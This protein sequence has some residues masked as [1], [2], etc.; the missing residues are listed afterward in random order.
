MFLM[1]N[2]CKVNFFENLLL[3]VVYYFSQLGYLAN[4]LFFLET[5]KLQFMIYILP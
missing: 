4:I 1:S 5:R 3:S 2:F